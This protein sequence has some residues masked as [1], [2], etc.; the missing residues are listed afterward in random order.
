ME[1][2]WNMFFIDSEHVGMGENALPHPKKNNLF[3]YK[4]GGR[5]KWKEY[6]S[7]SLH[8]KNMC[9]FQFSTIGWPSY[10]KYRVCYACLPTI[11]A[12]TPCL[13]ESHVRL[14]V[15]MFV[16]PASTLTSHM[17]HA[18]LKS[19]TDENSFQY[20]LRILRLWAL[21]Y[22]HLGLHFVKF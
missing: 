16:R 19:D 3:F 14:W 10:L 22:Y 8:P 20:I 2:N 9:W 12:A 15:L 21:G 13:P 4:V 18:V 5:I 11:H 17:C 6:P 7:L 1:N